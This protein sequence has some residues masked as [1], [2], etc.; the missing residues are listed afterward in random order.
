MPRVSRSWWSARFTVVHPVITSHD[1]RQNSKEPR[2]NWIVDDYFVPG[3]RYQQWLGTSTVW[4]HRTIENYFTE[5][6]KA[7]FALINLRSAHLSPTDL[8][9]SLSLSCAVESHWCCFSPPLVRQ[10][11]ELGSP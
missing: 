8:T 5:L 4:H 11:V 3:P 2:Q 9:T 1:P 6:R 7:G 10:L